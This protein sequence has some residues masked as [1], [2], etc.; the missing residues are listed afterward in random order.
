MNERSKLPVFTRST[1]LRQAAMSRS[2]RPDRDTSASRSDSSA[3][4]S[5]ERGF[6]DDKDSIMLN[7]NDSLSSLAPSVSLDSDDDAR[8]RAIEE[9]NRISPIS[10][11]PAELMIAVFAKLSSPA[12]LKNCMLV[13]KD[14]SRNSV[15]LLW[16]RPS[17]NKWTNVKSVIHTIRTVASFFEYSSLIKRLNLSALGNEVSDGTLGPLSVCKRVERLTLTNCTKLTDLSLEAMLE[18]NRSLLA[19]DVTS[20]EA[21]TDRTM[22][23]LAKNAVRLQGLNITNCRKITDDSLEEVAKSCRHLKRLKLN[24]CSQLTD[25][26]II[27][28]AMNCRYILEIDLHDCKNLADE[29]I[30]TLITEGPQLRELRLAHCWRI[31]DQAFLRLPSEA[32][33]E[34]LRILDL[35][36]C[37]ELND[38][39]VQKIVYAAPRLRNLVLAKCR[40][41]TDRAVLAITRLGKNLHYIHLGHCS[42]ITDVGVAQLVKLCNR[43]RY[44]DLACCTNLTDQSVMQLATLPKLKRIGLVKCAAITDR[45]ILALAKPKQVGSGGPIAPSVQAFLRDDLLVFCREAPPEFNEH[46]RDVFCVFSGLGVGRLRLFLNTHGQGELRTYDG[47]GTMY[48]DDDGD[49]MG[50]VTAQA[51]GMVMDEGEE[52]PFGDDSEMLG[53]D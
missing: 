33:Y 3:S 45:S 43:I 29:S 1:A 46:Q 4:T 42:R 21:L 40:N 50:N 14:W 41:I 20:V 30:T 37:G 34:S 44:I 19:L 38:A 6:D 35:T 9:Q 53:Q 26:S 2:R 28:F 8:R 22:L 31:T 36:D 47:E 23:A 27:A 12:D 16:H 49:Q 15:G 5:P 24:G 48:A 51:A 17:T 13:S 52:E 11:L 10:R 25:R 18:G 32:S 39:G 7:S